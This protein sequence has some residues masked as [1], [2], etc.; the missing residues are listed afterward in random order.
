MINLARNEAWIVPETLCSPRWCIGV[1]LNF[2]SLVLLI[3]NFL[4]PLFFNLYIRNFL[5]TIQQLVLRTR[6][7]FRD[8]FFLQK[9]LMTEGPRLCLQTSPSQTFDR[10][11]N[12]L[13]RRCIA[14]NLDGVFLIKFLTFNILLF[15]LY[16]GNFVVSI[17]QHFYIFFESTLS[18]FYLF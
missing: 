18:P 4:S 7:D 1:I 15:Y 5:T 14:C 11:L 3:F 17:L 12:M 9:Q 10:V 6:S 13:L 2:R 8:E 16:I